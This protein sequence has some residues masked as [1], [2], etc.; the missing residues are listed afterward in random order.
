M[1]DHD[2]TG[3]VHAGPSD[4]PPH[5][6]VP[7]VRPHVAVWSWLAIGVVFALLG[8]LLLVKVVGG[9][10]SPVTALAPTS[11]Q[12]FG[13]VTGVPAWVANDVGVN[14]PT[15]PVHPPS[16]V[17]NPLLTTTLVAHTQPLPEVLYFGTEFC[18]FCAAERWPLIVALSRFG[19]FDQLFDMQSSLV[20][21]A[22]GTQTFSFWGTT[23]T[24][25]YIV[26]RPFEVQSDV[27]GPHGFKPLM[28]VPAKLHAVL[29]RFDPTSTYPF[30]DVANRVVLRQASLSPETLAGLTRNQIAAR[31]ADPT[32]AVTQAILVAANELTASICRVD[33]EQPRAVCNSIGVLSADAVLRHSR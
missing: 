15:V 26:F 3:T 1:F 27:V 33:S 17:A 29:A 9:T 32:S 10:D 5:H 13:E 31:L 25:R 12:V 14:S 4:V 30:V 6:G 22:P 2:D 16:V 7:P 24:S 20:D 19:H 28:A 11:P 18:S 8:T 23:Y 21:Y